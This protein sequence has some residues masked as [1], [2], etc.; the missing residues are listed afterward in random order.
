MKRYNNL[1]ETIINPE[2]LMEGYISASKTKKKNHSYQAFTMD[3]YHNIN[4]IS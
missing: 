1:Y 3:L 2:N 4:D